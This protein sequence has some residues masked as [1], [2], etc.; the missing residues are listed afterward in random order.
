MIRRLLNLFGWP[1][2]GDDWTCPTC[3]TSQGSGRAQC[4][5]GCGTKGPLAPTPRP[6]APGGAT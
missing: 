3:G 2:R 6:A 5:N 4:M 1:K